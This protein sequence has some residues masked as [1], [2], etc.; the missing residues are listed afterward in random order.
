MKKIIAFSLIS[1][2][3]SSCVS[4]RIFNNLESR[5]AQ[6]KDNY[7][8]QSKTIELQREKI[9]YL[10][11]KYKA[12]EE[13]LSFTQ[14]SLRAKNQTLDKL[15][16]SLELLKENSE[17][18]LKARIADNE[19]L[20]EKIA[21]R[22]N[23]LADRIA[24]VEE[25][26]RLIAS[27]KQAMVDLKENLSD[28]LLNYKDKGLTV[29]VRDSKVYISMENKLLFKSGSWTLEL[30]GQRAISSLGDVLA[31]NPDIS[32]LIEGHTDNIPYSGRGSL[33]GNW[34]LSTKRATS[35]VNS[36]L[37]NIL[38][39]PQNLT[40]AGRGEYLPIATNSTI[41]GRAANRRIEVILSPKL[42]EIS[43]IINTLD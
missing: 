39:L 31:D 12:K 1:F 35:I 13:T 14:D 29:E 5:Y 40:A 42:D 10:D 8:R 26:E 38:I 11:E 16:A 36:L 7:N 21:D 43:Q 34:D 17:S 37:D 15:H 22:E 19:E 9:K 18:A 27:Q 25:L 6:L 32:I 4:S 3:L 23:E 30:E 2:T 24:R 33:K 41:E 20:M 28:A